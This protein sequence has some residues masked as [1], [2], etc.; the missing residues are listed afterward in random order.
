MSLTSQRPL[1]PKLT[2]LFA[3]MYHLVSK[4]KVKNIQQQHTVYFSLAAI[5]WIHITYTK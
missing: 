2:N 3:K 1:F 4:A 5:G